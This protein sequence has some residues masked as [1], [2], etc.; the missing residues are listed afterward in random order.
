MTHHNRPN[1]VGFS[2][3]VV[4]ARNSPGAEFIALKFQAS[5]DY[6]GLYTVS[7]VDDEDPDYVS[8]S[9]AGGRL[10]SSCGEEAFYDEED[11]PDEAK[12]LFYADISKLGNGV[13]SIVD[14]VSE[15]VLVELL[16]GLADADTYPSRDK[17]KQAA[18][19]A[20]HAYWRQI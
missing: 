15:Y 16:P 9:F 4:L 8:I 17:F 10:F 19:T 6:L 20:F 2:G 12:L 7:A 13:P 3:A 1:F 11:V 18:A 5:F 14:K